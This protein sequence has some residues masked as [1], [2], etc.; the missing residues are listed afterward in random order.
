MATQPGL[1]SKAAAALVQPYYDALLA[2]TPSAVR[3]SVGAVTTPDWQN[4]TDKDVCEARE[5]AI[6]RW[7][8]I[9]KLIPD[10]NI[11]LSEVLVTDN[12]V[13]ARGKL[14]GS[15]IGALMGVDP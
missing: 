11:E 2:R 13:I 7:S 3:A 14:S 10:F 4:C 5:A 1:S 9:T 12:T 8:E 6:R 15:P